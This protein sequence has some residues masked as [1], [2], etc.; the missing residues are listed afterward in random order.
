MKL[1]DNT[2]CQGIGAD[3]VTDRDLVDDSGLLLIKA[4]TANSQTRCWG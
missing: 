1:I 2:Y 3:E 4:K